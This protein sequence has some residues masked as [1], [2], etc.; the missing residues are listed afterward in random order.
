MSISSS[1]DT[2]ELYLGDSYFREGLIII[3]IS[4]IKWSPPPYSRNTEMAINFC[5]EPH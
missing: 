1:L 4:L 2:T 5:V 3:I